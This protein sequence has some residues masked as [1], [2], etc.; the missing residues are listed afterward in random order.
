MK[1]Y[2]TLFIIGS[3]LLSGCSNASDNTKNSEAP[4][5]STAATSREYLMY[6]RSKELKAFYDENLDKPVTISFE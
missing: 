5:T 3:A 6:E 4:R 2:L 1:K